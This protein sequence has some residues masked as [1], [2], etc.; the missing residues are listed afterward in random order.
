MAEPAARWGET[1]PV[2][3]YP[4][5]GPPDHR[6]A[7]I[8]PHVVNLTGGEFSQTGEMTSCVHE[9]DNIFDVHLPAFVAEVQQRSPG[10]PVPLI[11]W[12]HGGI[13]SESAG[14]Q[15]AGNQVPWWLANDVYPLHF[16]WETG[17][18]E[19]AKRIFRR[20]A[21]QAL[22]AHPE[23]RNEAADPAAGPVLDVPQYRS[24]VAARPW[25]VL[26]ENAARASDPGGG[27]RYVAERLA[28]FCAD[29]RGRVSLHAAGH[30][31]GAIFHSHFLPAARAVGVPR[32]DSLQLLAP[33]IRIDGF[34]KS[35]LPLVDEDIQ[36]LTVY[37]M[38]MQAENDDTCFRIYRRSLLYLV[39]RRFEP[40]PDAPI[41]GLE[42]SIRADPELITAFGLAAGSPGPAQVIWSP[43]P[44]GAPLDS[45][46]RAV[47]HGGFD[48]DPDTMNSVAR[49]VLGRT[50]IVGFPV[51]DREHSGWWRGRT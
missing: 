43:T 11:I 49:R 21:K 15:I 10:R 34:R 27:A 23:L 46:S 4:C 50:G 16:V 6:W 20:R 35:M 40:E 7:G 5:C 1:Q 44:A 24:K 17:F 12:A 29:Y 41:L 48:N 37:T 2:S 28:R 39:S 25:I 3:G 9:V 36:R 19:T 31:A 8:R 51:A 13:V 47:T 32:F 42:Q 45:R 14:L 38:N 18:L 33:A 22:Q 30:S 26:K